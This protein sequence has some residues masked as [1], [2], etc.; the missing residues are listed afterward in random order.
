MPTGDIVLIPNMLRRLDS[1][2]LLDQTG[3]SRS[4]RSLKSNYSTQTCPAR[5]L[6][7][8]LAARTAGSLF[9][10][11]WRK[12]Q[13]YGLRSGSC[14]TCLHGKLDTGC[15][16]SFWLGCYCPYTDSVWKLLTL[17]ATDPFQGLKFS[18]V[19]LLGEEAAKP[20]LQK[21]GKPRRV[22]QRVEIW[23]LQGKTP[24]DTGCS[25]AVC[26]LAPQDFRHSRKVLQSHCFNCR[27]LCETQTKLM[28][29]SHFACQ[30]YH[31][32]HF[33]CGPGEA[34]RAWVWSI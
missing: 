16:G 13:E 33:P 1:A 3:P 28:G 18:L 29:L 25:V 31:R 26:R 32:F 27:S 20:F 7:F 5:T 8:L 34:V 9:S 19:E 15:V 12:Q 17:A 24:P 4:W 22:L 11:L 30:D 14:L 10:K 21:P 6:E 2:R 23:S